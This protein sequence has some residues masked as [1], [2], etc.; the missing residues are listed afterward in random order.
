MSRIVTCSRHDSETE[1]HFSVVGPAV[2]AQKVRSR[3]RSIQRIVT[4]N[5]LGCG[6]CGV[7][8]HTSRFAAI[9][10]SWIPVSGVFSIT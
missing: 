10:V 1:Q 3:T 4:P 2:E 9:Y 6:E 7:Y 5:D 8:G